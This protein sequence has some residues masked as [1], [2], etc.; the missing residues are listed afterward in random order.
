MV[1]NN[2][3]SKEKVWEL[4]SEIPDPDIPVL[5]IVE[6]GLVRD[7]EVISESNVIVTLTPS[8]SGCPAMGVFKDDII[9]ALNSSGFCEVEIKISLSPAW[10]TDWMSDVAKEKMRAHGIAPPEKEPESELR[11]ARQKQVTCPHCGKQETKLVSRFG[12][13]PC[14][15]LWYCDTCEQPFEYFKCF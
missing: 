1:I 5:S 3:V 12:S 8:Y 2:I 6:L 4:L 13:T 7:V 9:T 14:K 10:T 11:F 15:A